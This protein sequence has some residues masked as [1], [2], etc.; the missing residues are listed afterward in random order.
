MKQKTPLP[1]AFVCIFLVTHTFTLKL[2]TC[3]TLGSYYFGDKYS[4]VDMNKVP[5]SRSMVIP[6]SLASRRH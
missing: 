4:S 3:C 6:V 1:V 5:M 2:D